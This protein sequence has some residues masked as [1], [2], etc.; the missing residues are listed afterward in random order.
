ME[1]RIDVNIAGYALTVRTERS[2]EHME[3]LAETLNGRVREIQKQGGSANYL[4][5]VMLA[6]MELAD[7]VLMFEERSREWKEQVLALR[8]EREALKTRLDRKSRD[9]LATLDAALK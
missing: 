3:R 7:E 8:T 6:A 1:N 2:A 5:I 4:N 9:L